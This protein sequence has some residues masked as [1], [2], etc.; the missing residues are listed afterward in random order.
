MANVLFIIDEATGQ[1][2]IEG[3][4]GEAALALTAG[5]LPPPRAFACARPLAPGTLPAT[6]P[7]PGQA[8]LRI[9]RIWHGS[10]AEG[11]GRRSVVQVAGCPIRC[12]GFIYSL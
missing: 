10:V 3:P 5:L 1:L 7:S 12:P 11:P 6:P 4:A 8:A 9:L 2:T